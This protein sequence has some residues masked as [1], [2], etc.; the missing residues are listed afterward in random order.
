[1]LTSSGPELRRIRYRTIDGLCRE[2]RMLET[3]CIAMT[4]LRLF[5]KVRRSARVAL[6]YIV[7][8]VL[9]IVIIVLLLLVQHC[10]ATF[11]TS[12][13]LLLHHR[14]HLLM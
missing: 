9:I 10:E 5:S 11:L 8:L 12:E 3:S 4:R 6:S 14:W 7:L 13:R 2:A 1:M